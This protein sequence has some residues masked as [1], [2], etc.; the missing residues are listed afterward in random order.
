MTYD[1]YLKDLKVCCEKC[2]GLC[3][4]A[5]YFSKSDGFPENKEAGNPCINLQKD[6][7]CSVHKKLR[8]KGLKGCIA[9]DCLG[10]GQKV[11]Q[12][13]FKG[14]NW[15]S[16]KENSNKMFDAF[17]LMR[18]LHEMLWYLTEAFLLNKDIKDEIELLI[19]ETDKLTLLEVD[20][21]LELDVDSHRDKVNKILKNTSEFIRTKA[22]TSKK[23]KKIDYFGANLKNAKL[24]GVDFRGACL[25]AAN[26]RGA[27]L[28]YADFIAAD[29]RDA[30]ISGAN[31][32]KSI[33]LTQAQI[34]TTKGDSN[35]KLPSRITRPSHWR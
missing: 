13:T 3:C 30:D 25:I 8:D 24:R 26:L 32:G 10:A 28:S 1:D 22:G 33:F 27:D 21:F 2:F 19:K 11:A 18:Q 16:D 12:V 14:V 34:N 5:L 20:D 29:M 15:R 6:F 4:T 35:T 23:K 17:I 9:Y 31:L 7:K